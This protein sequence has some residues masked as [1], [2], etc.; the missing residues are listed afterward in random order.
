M[1][2]CALKSARPAPRLV[3][4]DYSLD[5]Q[6]DNWKVYDVMVAGVSPCHQLPRQLRPG[7]ARRWHRRPDQVPSRTRTSNSKPRFPPR[8]DP[9]DGAWLDAEGPFHLLPC[10]AT[11]RGGRSP[12]CGRPGGRPGRRHPGWISGRTGPA[13]SAG[14]RVARAPAGSSL[15]HRRPAAQSLASSTTSIPFCLWR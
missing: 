2:G 8:N 4:I 14:M 15:H 3:Q 1:L 13:A 12:G 6:G 11:G 7:S 10:R 9:E 5:K